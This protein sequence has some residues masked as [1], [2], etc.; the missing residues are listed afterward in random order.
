L[1]DL[2]QST[3]LYKHRNSFI[4]TAKQLL[5]SI[6]DVSPFSNILWKAKLL[7]IIFL[8]AVGQ[9]EGKGWI[10]LKNIQYFVPKSTSGFVLYLK[11]YE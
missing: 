8:C 11:P 5:Y 9:L 1:F 6:L 2:P 4:S 3:D 7:E 10:G